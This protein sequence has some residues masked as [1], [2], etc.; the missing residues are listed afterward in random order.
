MGAQSAQAYKKHRAM[1]ENKTAMFDLDLTLW[2]RDDVLLGE[3]KYNTDLF[4]PQTIDRLH[5]HFQTLL[6]S[7][8]KNPL[9]RVADLPL[10][11]AEESRQV[12]EEWNETERP[13]PCELA[14]H[15][16]VAWQVERTPNALAVC[17]ENEQLSYRELQRRAARLAA[18]LQARGIQPERLV[19][20]YTERDVNW[21]CAVLALCKTG[22]VYLPLDPHHPAR[23][24]QH[25]VRQSGCQLILTTRQLVGQ[26][27]DLLGEDAVHI[28]CLED[29][30]EQE[31]NHPWLPPHYEA[32]HLAYVIYTSGSTG[33]PKGVMVEHAGMLNHLFAKI[34][35]LGLTAQDVVAQTASQ[36]F[37]ISVWQLLAAWLVGAQVRIYPETLCLDAP[38]LLQ[39]LVRDGISILEVVPSLLRALLEEQSGDRLASLRW[40][41]ATG[42]ALPADLCHLSLQR[43]PDLPLLNAYGP[44][45]CSDDV[46]HHL[47]DVLPDDAREWSQGVPIGKAI[48]NL[49]LYVLDRQQQ[50]QPI[51]ICGEIY[52]GG[53]GVGRGYLGDPAR[54]AEAFVPDPWSSQPGARLYRT[55][56]LGRFRPDG[57]LQYLGRIDQQVKLRGYRIELGEIEQVF[58]EQVG[59]KECLVVVREDVPGNQRLVAYV[60]GL[61][62]ETLVG[63]EIRQ[64][65]R[66]ALPEYMIPATIVPLEQL[67]LTPNG[68]VDRQALPR[69]EESEAGR[70]VGYVAPRTPLEEQLAAIWRELLGLERVGVYDDFFAVG[71]HSLLTVRLVTQIEK[72]LGKRLPLTVV[73][74][75]RTIEALAK[76]LLLHT[77]T[78]PWS[79]A[80]ETPSSSAE[81][82][83]PAEAVLD[84]DSCPEVWPGELDLE[85]ASILL[86]G[87]TGFLGTFLLA[88]LLQR[89]SAD[90]YCLVRAAS[91]SKGQEKLQRA[92]EHAQLWQPAF[93]NRMKPVIGDL[94][95]P[96]LG[97]SEQ[98]FERLARAIDAIYH[99]G[100]LVNMVYAYEDLKAPN[101]LGTKEIIRLATSHKIKPLH[102]VSTLSVFPHR[103]ATRIQHVREQES[104]DE[105]H[106][107]VRGGYAQSKW[108][109]EKLVTIA[110][111]R[112][113]PTVIYR[114]GR[115][116]GHSQSG[117][118]PT[119]DVLCRLIKGC[120]QLGK[121]P[122]FPAEDVLEMTPVDYV[123][124][125]I[126]ALS[127][128]KASLGQAFHLHIPVGAPINDV[129]HWINTFG[130]PLQQV[131]Y[132]EWLE[133]L[134]HVAGTG[135][136][137]EMTP[138]VS[139]LPGNGPGEQAQQAPVVVQDNRST[140]AALSRVAITCPPVDARLLHTY[141]SYMV[142]SNFLPA[143]EQ[144]R[145]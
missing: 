44:T 98:A 71:G 56:D 81:V 68:K 37:D 55:G 2:E 116:T 1:D 144:C 50:P 42:E 103:G 114:P 27:R 62:G 28:C 100:A 128:R 104:I 118:W 143:P 126:V 139:L 39:R 52:V 127:R 131:E 26:L 46:T 117:V 138:F 51:N 10:L 20:L 145:A 101:V 78:S 43:Q 96:L 129:I 99:N 134:A 63:E 74:Q 102:Y 120:I 112:G 21:A 87:A 24:L 61:N 80:I 59:V 130:Y 31:S 79:A 113:L 107:Y 69:P 53:I 84:L 17:D 109:A 83:L 86:T 82:N 65:L 32:N 3:L 47:I 105:Y 64:R 92:L 49:R 6:E 73:F 66:E 137:N 18:Y 8:V 36:C 132:E 13:Y 133:A 90:I 30:L 33:L 25:I 72:Q 122:L 119:D 123:S 15:D 111:S 125:S 58:R 89:T 85:P 38:L 135:A 121:S 110:R 94:A 70:D 23:R 35:T 41:I 40:L 7:I 124:R 136:S 54:T 142:Q 14:Y 57:T 88:E 106:E 34:E 22:G 12:I 95:R 19:G 77:A 45:E 140:L 29:L 9:Q 67:P 4:D 5:E 91:E 16:Y 93:G 48:G 141:L 97:L 75:G 11:T 60:V 108:V 115:I 76:A